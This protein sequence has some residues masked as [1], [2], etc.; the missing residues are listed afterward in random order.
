MTSSERPTHVRHAVV[1]V[2]AFAAFLMYLDR[3]CVSQMVN[4][5]TFR[6]E[7]GFSPGATGW[8]L[9]AFFFAY[10]IGQVPA[11]WLADR[12]GARV[13][14]TAF[15]ALWSLFTVLTGFAVGFW[16]LMA[17]RIGCGLAEASA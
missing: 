6:R 2:T 5:D 8:V 12:F 4:D 10:A 1:G 7:M 14:M 11:G 15:I 13:L 9:S 3:M 17:A 16:T